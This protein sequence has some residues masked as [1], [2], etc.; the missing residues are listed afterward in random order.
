MLLDK[1]IENYEETISQFKRDFPLYFADLFFEFADLEYF[2]ITGYTPSFNDGDPCIF[3]ISSHGVDFK[4]LNDK[5]A[6]QTH[7]VDGN[8]DE[9][10]ESVI[11]VEVLKSVATAINVITDKLSKVAPLMQAVF[12]SNFQLDVYSDKLVEKEYDC[13]Y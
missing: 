2:S 6:L 12:G 8:Y 13:G 3:R 9:D 11:D 5:C 1:M 10:Y 4:M 7:I